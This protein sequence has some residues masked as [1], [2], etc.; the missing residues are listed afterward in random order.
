MNFSVR[1]GNKPLSDSFDWRTKCAIPAVK[2]LI[3][4]NPPWPLDF[5]LY[6]GRAAAPPSAPNI[7]HSDINFTVLTNY[8]LKCLGRS[9]DTIL[10]LQL[11]D[12]IGIKN[13]VGW[14]A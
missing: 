12:G 2:D 9:V 14:T 10:T 8:F 5:M 3:L 4:V 1:Y 11:F 13:K 6:P 7:T